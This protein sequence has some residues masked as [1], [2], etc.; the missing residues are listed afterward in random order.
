MAKYRYLVADL[1][2]GAIRDEFPMEDVGYGRE[3]NAAGGFGARLPLSVKKAIQGA[4]AYSSTVLADSPRVYY[5]LGEL[6]G[7]TANDSTTNAKHGT[8]TGTVALAVDGAILADKN[9]AVDLGNPSAGYVDLPSDAFVPTNSSFT[10]EAWVYR[11]GAPGTV[12]RE[13]NANS[14]QKMVDLTVDA[15][16]AVKFGTNTAGQAVTAAG[17]VPASTWAHVVGTYDVVTGLATI[18]VN[19][20]QRAQSAEAPYTGTDMAFGGGIGGTWFLG[21]SAAWPGYLD[22]VALYYNA[23]S[24]SRVAAHY[25]AGAIEREV[26]TVSSELITEANLAPGKSLVL[27]ERDAVILNGYILWSVKVDTGSQTVD[28]AGQGVLSYLEK[29]FIRA[30]LIYTAT[31][32]FTIAQGILNHVQGDTGGNL[33]ITLV[34]NPA[35]GSGVL[36]DRTYYGFERKNALE[37]LQELGGVQNGFDFELVV[38]GNID[39]V[40]KQLIL[41]YPMRGIVTEFVWEVGKDVQ[42]LDYESNAWEMADRVAAIGEGE[43]TLSKIVE[44]SDSGTLTTYPLY[45]RVDQFK[46]V[47][48]TATL[49]DHAQATLNSVKR[50]KRTA[51]VRILDAADSPIGSYAPGDQVRLR[52]RGGFLDLDEPWRIMGDVVHVDPQGDEYVDAELAP[53][54]AFGV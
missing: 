42:L 11:I 38:G 50:G 15:T 4:R 25:R 19:G 26:T 43:G 51:S 16:G 21:T 29:R 27:V 40:L 10:V 37:A 2:T 36:R 35:A 6:T 3:L 32:Q 44:R 49:A 1:L 31:E 39:A 22:E 12:Y 52:A 47:K 46:D 9:R 24:A 45:D 48:N 18:Y 54:E 28:L 8:Y 30:N 41:A 20:V 5:R 23:L 13:L 53:L 33:G 34:K 7:T 14:D 17:V